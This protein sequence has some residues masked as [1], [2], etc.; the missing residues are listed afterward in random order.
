MGLTGFVR[1]LVPVPVRVRLRRSPL[2]RRLLA[3]RY[4]GVRAAQ[5]PQAPYTL[6]FDGYNC[7]GWSMGGLPQWEAGPFRMVRDLLERHRPPVVWDIGANI[8]LWS[9]FFAGIPGGPGRIVSFEPDPYNQDLL[10]LNRERNGIDKITI[11][12]LA[13]SDSSGTVEFF[14]DD[15]SR[16]TGSIEE[17]GAFIEEMYGVRRRRTTV[18]TTTIDAEVAGGEPPPGLIKMD[19]EGHEL[20]VLRGGERTLREHGPMIFMEVSKNEDAVTELLHGLGYALT[21]ADTG[22]PTERAVFS[23]LAVRPPQT[24]AATG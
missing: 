2:V 23:T 24:A 16:S 13:L 19:V 14:A 1:S 17:G 9:L 21:D 10:R 5:H 12:G 3:A 15:L 4:G 20:K 11:K 7:L 6:H 8:G 18:Q 22:R